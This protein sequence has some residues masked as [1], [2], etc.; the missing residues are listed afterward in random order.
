MP[1]NLD[2]FLTRYINDS[3]K[4]LKN[5]DALKRRII[6][7]SSYFRSAQESLLPKYN[8][9][10]GVDYHIVRIPMSDTQFKIYEG[11]RKQER[12]LEKKKPKGGEVGELFEEKA[13]TYRI[14]S[15]L[16]CNFIMPDRPIPA[17]K[18]K[19]EEDEK[20]DKVE[21]ADDSDMAALIK[22]GARIES[23]QDVED[24][25]EGE[26]E[27]DEVLE[28]LGGT[29]YKSRLERE[30]KNIEEHSNDFL[31]PE[32]LQT[33]SPKF[34][35]MLENIDDKEHQGLHLVYSQ[36]RTAEGIGLFTLVLEKNGFA[37]FVIKIVKFVIQ[38]IL[39]VKFVTFVLI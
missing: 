8:K 26:I 39:K 9:Q 13:S 31:T 19:T 1:D 34:L 23:K 30:I 10:L 20:E 2:T 28:A 35:H 3:D 16:F 18:K 27:G 24:E 14:F 5:V 21:K 22:E 12:D 25:R 6:G 15:R 7:L 4:K 36:F 33:Y 11:A 17:R 32:A 29:D 37:R 38:N